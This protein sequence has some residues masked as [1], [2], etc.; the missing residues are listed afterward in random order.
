MFT[1]KHCKDNVLVLSAAKILLSDSLVPRLSPRVN[2]KVLQVM[3]SWAG[4]GTRLLIRVVCP[5]SVSK[6]ISEHLVLKTSLESRPS[7]HSVDG[8]VISL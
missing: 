6:V 3:E 2:E 5:I 1:T 7:L 4:P 8:C